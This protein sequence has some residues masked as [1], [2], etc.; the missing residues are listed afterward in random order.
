VVR[1]GDAAAYRIAVTR[2]DQDSADV[3]MDIIGLADL[4]GDESTRVRRAVEDHWRYAQASTVDREQ[5]G[6]PLASFQ[7]VQFQLTDAE[8]ERAGAEQLGKFALWSIESRQDESIQDALAFR[9]AAVEAADR[10]FRVAHQLHG[11]IG[12]CDETMLSWVSFYSLPLRRLPFGWSAT[13]DQ[14]SRRVGRSGLSGPFRA[15]YR[16]Q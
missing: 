4:T 1:P 5:F 8:V 16:S 10:V 3:L 15:E 11:A 14:L 12:F 13:L 2:L 9:L 6:R 7:G